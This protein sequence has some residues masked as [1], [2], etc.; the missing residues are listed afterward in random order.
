MTITRPGEPGQIALGPSSASAV[1][2]VALPVIIVVI[3]SPWLV[4]G[5][6][7]DD[8]RGE[9]VAGGGLGGEPGALVG[10]QSGVECAEPG[11][12]PIG[13]EGSEVAEVNEEVR[14]VSA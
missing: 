4:C 8:E 5:Q 3:G 7:G 11:G 10:C 1:V 12:R 2:V 14:F 6:G 13:L 9:R